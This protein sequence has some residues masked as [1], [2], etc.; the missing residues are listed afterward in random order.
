M[1]RQQQ[2]IHESASKTSGIDA[3][4]LFLLNQLQ[5]EGQR[6]QTKI[7]EMLTDLKRERKNSFETQSRMEVLA[8][9]QSKRIELVESRYAQLN[10]QLAEQTRAM[11]AMEAEITQLRTYSDVGAMVELQKQMK[12]LQAR[13]QTKSNE[14]IQLNRRL[15]ETLVQNEHLKQNVGHV[16][17]SVVDN[18]TEVKLQRAQVENPTSVETVNVNNKTPRVKIL[19][20]FSTITD[21]DTIEP[22]DEDEDQFGHSALHINP[23]LQSN[24][25]SD[26]TRVGYQST[27]SVTVDTS[28]KQASSDTF[29]LMQGSPL[30]RALTT[31]VEEIRNRYNK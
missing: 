24:A 17:S 25:K 19:R 5:D 18:L 31:R 1:S 10:D 29:V 22:L 3:N 13:W 23:T 11:A 15:S 12:Q 27:S 14:C 8:D 28:R 16:E 20:K 21:K 9:T 6:K 30:Q 4:Y 2:P 7:D 26:N